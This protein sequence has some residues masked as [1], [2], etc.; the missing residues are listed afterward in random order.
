MGMKS[1]VLGAFAMAA[2]PVAASAVTIDGGTAG[3]PG[4]TVNGRTVTSFT[5][6]SPNPIS[7]GET[8]SFQLDFTSASD[9][10][11]GYVRVDLVANP[12]V[13]FLAANVRFE[14]PVNALGDMRLALGSGGLD[15]IAQWNATG[16]ADDVSEFQAT[17]LPPGAGGAPDG[18]SANAFD[19]ALFSGFPPAQLQ[20]NGAIAGGETTGFYVTWDGFNPAAIDGVGTLLVDITAGEPVINTP[21]PLPPTVIML[22]AGLVGF[23]FYGRKK[24]ASA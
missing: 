21:V 23:G 24:N 11:P 9:S 15:N 13:S 16:V 2:L 12:G 4:G 5:A 19:A 20:F 10:G 7:E 18:L 8:V 3:V 1:L 22:L 14:E 6:P 17:G